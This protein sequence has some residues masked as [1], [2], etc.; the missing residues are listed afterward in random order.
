MIELIMYELA[1][2]I[3]R[4]IIVIV[5]IV[6]FAIGVLVWLSNGTILDFKYKKNVIHDT[7]YLPLK[8]H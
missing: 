1:R 3:G 4:I 5:G 8:Q 2:E 7:I 6:L